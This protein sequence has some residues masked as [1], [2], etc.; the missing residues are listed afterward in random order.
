[1]KAKK[2][3]RTKANE[4]DPTRQG[5]RSFT[6]LSIKVHTGTQDFMR[7]NWSIQ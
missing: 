3:L 5:R 7:Q 6:F 1:M 2:V 4:F